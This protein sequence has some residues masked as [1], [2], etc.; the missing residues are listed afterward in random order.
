MYVH[1]LLFYIF[2]HY[3][4][5]TLKYLYVFS[6]KYLT[7]IPCEHKSF[8]QLSWLDDSTFIAIANLFVHERLK[9]PEAYSE[10]SRTSKMELF[11][12]MIAKSH[13]KLFPQNAVSKLFDWVLNMSRNG[14]R[15]IM[16]SIRI[17]SRP[18][19]RISKWNQ[20]SQFRRTS[21]KVIPIEKT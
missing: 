11:A 5:S 7:C 21:T 14:D 10:P 8:R 9:I 4:T 1:V 2:V 17:T 15:K 6:K 12:K 3:C 20:L 18:P 16:Q 13:L 19:S